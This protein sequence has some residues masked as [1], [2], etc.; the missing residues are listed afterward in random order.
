MTQKKVGNGLMMKTRKDINRIENYENQRKQQSE[1]Q[2]VQRKE[3]KQNGIKKMSFIKVLHSIRLKLTMYFLIPILFILILGITAY[4]NASKSLIQTFTQA[5]ISSFDSM[6]DYYRVILSNIEDK[7]TQLNNN[8]D[9]ANL[10][11]GH[12]SSDVIKELEIYKNV[13][14]TVKKTA[15]T[16]RY[17]GSVSIIT[18]YGN[19]ITT[20]NHF[21]TSRK[22]Y[23]EFVAS[24]EGIKINK[25]D[26]ASIWSGYHN[27]IDNSLKIQ[28]SDYGFSLTTKLVNNSF[29][30]IGYIII[31][32]KMNIIS[33]ALKS[34]DLPK[35]SMVAF[36][37]PDGR[38]ITPAGKELKFQFIDKSY[39]KNA[40]LSAQN[41]GNSYVNVNGIKYLF[42]YSKV[43]DTGALL[44]ALIPST[45]LTDK[46]GSIKV[47]TII[48]VL[49]A[50]SIASV[51]GILVAR[52]ISREIKNI[53]KK[54]TLVA[55]G[56]LTV[57]IQT[58]RKD[59]F[60]VLTKS[61]NHMI[62]NTREL[63]IKASDVGDSVIQSADYVN[64]NSE[65]L[66]TSSK[67]ISSA[68]TEIQK[69][70]I[71]Q[72]Y[73]TERCLQQANES[74]D[75]IN[76]VHQNTLDIEKIAN[77][78][79]NKVQ[80]GIEKVEQLDKATKSNIVIINETM[81]EIEEL[82]EES[83]AI[84]EIVVVMDSIADQTNLLSLN[85]SIEAARA[86]SYGRN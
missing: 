17:I 46:A 65:L 50:T 25:S 49:I 86:G 54:L 7:A 9:A 51:M 59:E 68:I 29:K 75:K 69:G 43:G 53:I 22:P 64:Q 55:E 60:K 74:T 72:A 26:K 41:K 71:Q 10:Y 73:D 48:I 19:S 1:L 38:E 77:A 58:K 6:S 67:D 45:S 13:S 57:N 33:D 44:C 24:E 8:T 32:V 37:S 84:T 52:G 34:L 23:E 35:N 56:D 5:N 78:T 16:D 70:I 27:Y 39:Y 63:I 21:G 3:H 85:A 66:L 81:Q 14:G 4:L 42:I 15:I 79:K 12:F 80:D 76:L 40:I 31:D 2:R 20:K 62:E 82:E 30:E 36:I 28:N 61:I 83:K 18:K 11:S 47:L